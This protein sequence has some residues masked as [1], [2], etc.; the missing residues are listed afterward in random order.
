MTLIKRRQTK[1]KAKTKAKGVYS[2]VV[3]TNRIN[4]SKPLT[5]EEVEKRQEERAKACFCANKLRINNL[6]GHHCQL[7]DL[8]VALGDPP[9]DGE[10]VAPTPAYIKAMDGRLRF[11]IE[12]SLY[13]DLE[14]AAFNRGYDMGVERALKIVLE[15][16]GDEALLGYAKACRRVIHA[17][18]QEHKDRI[19]V[20]DEITPG[21]LSNRIAFYFDECYKRKRSYTVPGLAYEVG[22]MCRQ[23][24]LDYVRN[25]SDTLIG[26]MLARALMVIE[27][28]RNTEIISGGGVMAGHKLDLA[29]N[30]SW[31]DA[32]KKD[33]GGGPQSVTNNN[34]TNINVHNQTLNVN[35]ESLPPTLTLDQWQAQFLM[36]EKKKGLPVGE[37]AIDVVATPDEMAAQPVKRGRGRPRKQSE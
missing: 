4:E 33:E 25:N 18:L 14:A 7:T 5:P 10:R 29:T 36:N 19:S 15:S 13:T 30:F 16:V 6:I 31:K 21:E 12:D 22:F 28:Q 2:D 1:E 35:P 20:M 26:Y 24:M 32:G 8:D 23:D 3:D 37:E 17:L 11:I 27:D 34:Q 9:F